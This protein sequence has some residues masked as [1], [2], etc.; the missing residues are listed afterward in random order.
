MP[1]YNIRFK[2]GSSRTETECTV[3]GTK[4]ELENDL[5][6]QVTD[7]LIKERNES[8]EFVLR[9]GWEVVEGSKREVEVTAGE[10]GR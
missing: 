5:A 4:D 10:R 6:A 1:Y 3:E 7:P 9:D 8:G 2:N